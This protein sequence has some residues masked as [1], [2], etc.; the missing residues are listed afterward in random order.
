MNFNVY[1]FRSAYGSYRW[2]PASDAARDIIMGISF[3]EITV[4]FFINQI[5]DIIEGP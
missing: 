4:A 5:C 2:P 3:L 1:Y